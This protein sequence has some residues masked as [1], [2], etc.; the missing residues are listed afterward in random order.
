M[1]VANVENNRAA[2]PEPVAEVE[3]GVTLL[4]LPYPFEAMLAICSDLDETPSAETYLATS[5]YLNTKD[6]TPF[7]E[8]VGLEVGNTIYFYM[9]ES[10]FAYWNTTDSTRAAIRDLI[11]SGHI[12][13][14]HS[15]GDTATSRSQAQ[16]TLDHLDGHGCRIRVWVDHAVARTNF[17]A[18]IMQGRG[19]VVDDQ[20]YHAD[21]T[22]AYGVEYV[23]RGR[24]TSTQGQDARRSLGGI[25]RPGRPGGS[26]VTL[27]KETVKVTAASLGNG[28]YR[29][30]RDNDLVADVRLRDASPAVEFLRTNPHP[31]G[32]SAGDNA[33]GLA[34]VISEAFLDRLVRRRAKAIVYT[35]LGKRIDPCE[36]FCERTR[37]ALEKLAGRMHAR[38]VLVATTA[39]VLDYACLRRRVTWRTRDDGHALEILV[40]THGTG[41]AC[42]GLSFT[43]P[44]N[45]ECRIVCGGL[46]VE[47]R[48][49]AVP[50]AS[51]AVVYVPWRSLDYAN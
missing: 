51:R 9:N 30:H 36:G 10:E 2:P 34:E 20:A 12:D 8:G 13:C 49:A 43:V 32:V 15:F 40:D 23:W 35:H 6:T 4:D 28:Q 45:R 41:R 29:M 47:S 46:P 24:V 38:Q 5:R 25:W 7:G 27:A 26:L 44:A 11:R 48:R 33:A 50:A 42:D 21:L 39:R 1:S 22:L 18:D 31:L 14:F 3:G 16:E 17:G 37:T 19:D